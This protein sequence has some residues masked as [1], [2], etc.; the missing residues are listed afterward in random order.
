MKKILLQYSFIQKNIA[1]QISFHHGFFRLVG[2]CY[3]YQINAYHRL[4]HWLYKERHLVPRCKAPK[5]VMVQD[6]YLPL[7]DD[8]VETVYGPPYCLVGWCCG[9]CAM[10]LADMGGRVYLRWRSGY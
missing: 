1:A 7:V 4:H 3:T 10:G 6:Q 9:S 2:K 8:V 5:L